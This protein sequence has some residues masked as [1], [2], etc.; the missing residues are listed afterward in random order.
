MSR[1]WRAGIV[2]GGRRGRLRSL[3]WLWRLGRGGA[4]GLSFR[5]WCSLLWRLRLVLWLR[6]TGSGMEGVGVLFG[7]G[8]A[9]WGARRGGEMELVLLLA[10]A[11][12]LMGMGDMLVLGMG[13]VTGL[14]VEVVIR[15]RAE[16]EIE[17]LH[18]KGVLPGYRVPSMACTVFLFRGI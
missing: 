12:R 7:M 3:G 2:L 11:G 6:C 16:R 15:S 17:L 8:M 4:L 9:F 14:G 18:S 13:M 10:M 1:G 5:S